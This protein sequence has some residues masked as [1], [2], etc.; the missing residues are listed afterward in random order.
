MFWHVIPSTM[1]GYGKDTLIRCHTMLL[2]I[3]ECKIVSQISNHV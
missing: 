3:P 1:L 2:V